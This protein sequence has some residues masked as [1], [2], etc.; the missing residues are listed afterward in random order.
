MDIRLERVCER[1]I[2][3][4]LMRLFVERRKASYLFLDED[5]EIEKVA[6]SVSTLHGESDIVVYYRST[7]E[8][9]A[10]LIENKIDAPAQ[11]EQNARYEKRG[12]Q[13][14]ESEEVA[15]YTIFITAPQEYLNQ[16]QEAAMYTNKVAYE[17][18][19]EACENE[20][21]MFSC[22]L[23]KK[24]IMKKQDDTIVDEAVTAFWLEYYKYQETFYPNLRLHK[25]SYQ[26]GPNATWPDFSTKER[27]RGTKILHKSE[28]GCVDLE[29]RMEKDEL[30]KVKAITRE[31]GLDGMQWVTTGKSE[32]IRIHVPR[33]DFSKSFELY[34]DEIKK[35]FEAVTQ[36]Y[37]IVE[38]IYNYPVH[39]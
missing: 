28:K 17:E 37:K 30:R 1:D 33:I 14:V 11:Q 23:L 25:S 21:D 6:H 5:C 38:N 7:G 24:A 19:L 39:K 26:K 9:Y 31:L 34:Q 18:I 27:I 15:G 29:F 36:L 3:L 32:S 13:M 10:L 20:N 35:V 16:N 2:D 22:V 4:L 8:R 12:Q